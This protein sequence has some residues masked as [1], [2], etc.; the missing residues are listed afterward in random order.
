[1]ATLDSSYHVQGVIKVF[2][3]TTVADGETWQ[4]D[5]NSG[6]AIKAF[7]TENASSSAKVTATF[8]VA[9]ST[10]TFACDSSTATVLLFVLM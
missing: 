5:S 3:L 2:K 8:T 1:M 4:M 6:T 7:W 9:T 10:F